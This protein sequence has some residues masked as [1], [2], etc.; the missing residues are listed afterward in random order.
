[1]PSI[2]LN[3]GTLCPLESASEL[4]EKTKGHN[5][6]Y[7]ASFT[8]KK[9]LIV[10]E[11]LG[12]DEEINSQY[13]CGKAGTLFDKLLSDV[14]LARS[15]IHV[16]NV[17]K[18]RPPNNK[19]DRLSEYNLS[20]SDFIPFLKEEIQNVNPTVILALGATA[21]NALCE[22]SGILKQRG[23]VLQCSLVPGITVVPTL[24]PSY[25]QRGQMDLYPYVRN[26][27]KIF[28][29]IGFGFYKPE[30]KWE[31]IIDPTLTQALSYLQE[32]IDSSTQTCLDIETVAKQRITCIGFTKNPNSSICIPLRYNG[33][34]LRW[35]EAEQI[36]LLRQMQKVFQ[37]KGLQKI[38]QNIHYD[39]HH[40]LPLIGFPR[41]PTFD[42]RYAHQL[43]HPDMRHDLGFI[44]SAYTKM[45]YHKD[46]VKDWASKDLP[47][48][49]TL[50]SYNCKDTIG[51]HRAALGLIKDLKE[52]DLYDFYCGYINPFRRVIFEMEH[53]GLNVNMA[54]H[55]E[56]KDYIQ[57]EELPI[58]LDI[59]N[60]KCGTDINPNSSK[61]IGEYLT[62]L[63]VI[64][65]RTTKG[66]F[67]VGE[68]TIETLIAKHPEHRFIL[69]Q[70]L[71]ARVLK[72]KDLGT[73]LSALIS[74]DDHL[75]CSYGYTVTGRLTSSTDGFGYGTNVQ[76][77]P[78]RMKEIIIPEPGHTFMDADLSAAEAR[79]MAYFMNSQIMKDVLNGP[80]KIHYKVGEWIYDKPWQE[81]NADEYLIAKK[82][83]HGS[84]YKMGVNLFSRIIGKPVHEARAIQE[85]YFTVVPEL[86][87]YHRDIQH[88]VE[89]NRRLTNPFGRTR[90]FT[91]RI[92]QT[93]IGSGYAQKPQS[94]I[95]DMMNFGILSLYLLKPDNIHLITQTHDSVLVSLPPQLYTWWSTYMKSHLEVLRRIKI[96]GD[97]LNIPIE[98][99]P[100]K[101]NWLGK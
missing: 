47:K 67:K 8:P 21:L 74:K 100:P 36:L 25:L 99:E 4:E 24:H 31:E 68:E 92:D 16:T 2:E 72:A 70:I 42:T 30:V 55:K 10:G 44:I 64:V 65:P 81:L 59:I 75:K 32:I 94:T 18:I 57:E 33:L 84:N 45:N 83:V 22:E 13:F 79:A 43:I 54:L 58:A 52:L 88:E 28:A 101:S 40:L 53:R 9:M 51:T 27:T 39:L 20:I 12:A 38:G 97:T 87:K 80:L 60:K 71:C 34:K 93:A 7:P 41:E 23:S 77:F 26:D 17:V 29:E 37:K 6:V 82:T 14:G 76:N 85:K 61:Q 5:L 3:T 1:M 49:H 90:I 56:W 19:L 15:S 73:Y 78:K 63:G 66:N 96:N 50:W 98:I 95:V 91:G 89:S 11:A 48:D 46:E 86:P 69:K 62:T 35:S